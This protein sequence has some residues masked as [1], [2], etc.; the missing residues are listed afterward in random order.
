MDTLSEEFITDHDEKFEV[1]DN[2]SIGSLEWIDDVASCTTGLKN[3]KRV[4]SIVDDFARR[5]KL[6]WGESKCEVMQ[7]GRKTKVPEEWELGEKERKNTTS[8]KYLGDTITSDN[9]NKRNLEIKENR[10]ESTIRQINTT[11]SSDH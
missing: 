1:N 9:K 4:L 6:E 11:A 10:V 5:N 2:F 3:Q 7:I 8:Y